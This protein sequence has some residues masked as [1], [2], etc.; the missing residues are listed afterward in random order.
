[1]NSKVWNRI[2]MGTIAFALVLAVPV[3]VKLLQERSGVQAVSLKDE[4]AAAESL[5]A[6]K[7]SGP[8]YFTVPAETRPEDGILWIDVDEALK[9][10]P[11]IVEQ[12][13]LGPGSEQAV[14]R[15][16]GQLSEP[17][18]YRMVGGKRINLPRL[19][20]SLDSMN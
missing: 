3:S 18:P 14:L 12:R 20:L 15:L 19:N 2:M 9:Q 6:D 7:L 11:G 17:H 16:I 5:L 1:M 4:R 10:V 13:K 8:E